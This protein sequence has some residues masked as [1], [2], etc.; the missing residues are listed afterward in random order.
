MKLV[1]DPDACSGHG[2]CYVYVPDLVD[3]DES[4]FGEVRADGEI[5]PEL[6][7]DARLA[8]TVCP[9]QAIRLIE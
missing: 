8:V 1:I 4:G 2:R 5:P 7:D 6:L 3:F 9:E